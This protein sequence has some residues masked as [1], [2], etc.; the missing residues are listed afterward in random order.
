M[1]VSRSVLVFLTLLV[2]SLCV[3][4]LAAEK[5][6]TESWD[7]LHGRSDDCRWQCVGTGSGKTAAAAGW[8]DGKLVLSYFTTEGTKL[9]EQSVT[10]PDACG[11]GTVFRLLPIRDGVAYLALY[12]EDAQRLYLFRVA[13]DGTAERLL[14]EKCPGDSFME[15]SARTSLSELMF[16][17]GVMSFALR[18]DDALECYICRENG[19][20]AVRRERVQESR[21]C[22]VLSSQD[23]TLLQ[24]GRGY[25]SLNGVMAKAGISDQT[26]THLTQCRG[27]W[28]YIDA[29]RFELCFVDA[30][31]RE[32]SRLL[33]LNTN[34][35]GGPGSLSSAALTQEEGV[36]M[37]LDGSILTLSDADGVRELTGILGPSPTGLRVT[38]I[39]FAAIAL[40]GA[41]LL[42]LLVCGRRKG[43]APLVVLRGSA[44]VACALL[45][46]T[47]L[48]YA[49][50]RPSARDSTRK[51]YE[52]VLS[53]ILRAARAEN[54][55]DD[56]SLEYDVALMLENTELGDN[57]RIMGIEW[58]DGT[59]KSADGRNAVTRGISPSLADAAR[60][61]GT[62]CLLERGVF[63]CVLARNDRGLSVRMDVPGVADNARLYGLAAGGF[64]I[65]TFLALLILAFVGRDIRRISHKMETISKGTVSEPLRL[66][67]GDELESMTSIVN[68]F[69]AAAKAQEESLEAVKQS[70][71]RFVPE[72]VLGLLEKKSI[73]EV[74]KSDFSSRRMVMMAVRFAF[75]ETLYTDTENSRLLFDS[76]NEVIERTAS[77]ATRKG[78]TVFHFAYNGFDLVMRDSAGAVSTAVA[79]QQEILSFNEARAESRLPQVVLRIALDRGNFMLG[80]VGDDSMLTPTA[81]SSNLSVVRELMELCDRLKAG[82]LCTES[83]ISQKQDYS[84]RYMGKCVVGGQSVRVYEVF[85]GDE[86]HTRRGKASSAQVF[87]KGVYDLYGGD[88][89]GAKHTFLELAHSNPLDG[90]ARYYLHL[91]DR[92]EH[93]PTLPCVL[94]LEHIG[95]EGL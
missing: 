55:L 80:I 31:L 16:E 33:A 22:S 35:E 57:A 7:A 87:A 34:R 11:G 17:D 9:S 12:G 63:C 95:R 1:R 42:W 48:R 66:Q 15:R 2:I 41:A 45:C 44:L 76:V 19:L 94:N 54:R 38:L 53:G 10:L 65:L 13:D 84:S 78:G 24:G 92:L 36:I 86:Y 29:V 90:G 62:S 32:T 49:V 14:T 23:G 64:G 77:I 52:A 51:D 89:V 20:E 71:R 18:R 70:Y 5:P 79:I 91:A 67:T 47:V 69:G 85:D 83:I 58:V 82:I 59:W 46:L 4:A 21:V 40:V 72:K 81:I 74:D 8:R 88:T 39:V 28:Y 61:D 26:V 73:Q 30:E 68:S 75:P 25:L 56:E 43:Y 60:R 37:L 27:G 50:L 93:D 6:I 3:V